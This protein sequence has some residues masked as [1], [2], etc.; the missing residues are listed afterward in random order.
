LYEDSIAEDAQVGSDITAKRYLIA[1][2]YFF[3]KDSQKT[4]TPKEKNLLYK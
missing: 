1:L 3:I 4:S 2:N